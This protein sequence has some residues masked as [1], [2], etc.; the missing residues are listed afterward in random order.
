MEEGELYVVQVDFMESAER[1]K[2]FKK[3]GIKL[4]RKFC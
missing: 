2:F 1:E 4:A 3:W